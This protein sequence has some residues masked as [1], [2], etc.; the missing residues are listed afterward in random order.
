M[1][2]CL[3][4][5]IFRN[6]HLVN[7]ANIFKI[8]NFC[9][10]HVDI[11]K[12]GEASGD[13]SGSK[14]GFMNKI[15][16]TT[17]SVFLFI[18]FLAACSERKNSA[19][20]S[21]DSIRALA[22]ADSIANAKALPDSNCTPVLCEIMNEEN[23]QRSRLD[24]LLATDSVRTNCYCEISGTRRKLGSRI[25]IVKEF[26]KEKYRS[27]QYH[28][29]PLQIACNNGDLKTMKMLLE[30]GADPNLCQNTFTKPMNIMLRKRDQEG[31]KLLALYKGNIKGC[32]VDVTFLSVKEMKMYAS[33][34]A[35]YNIK[36]DFFQVPTIMEAND[37]AKRKYLLEWGVNPND[38]AKGGE[39][40]LHKL[41]LWGDPA[42]IDL[43]LKYKADLYARDAKGNT[44]L[45]V[46]ASTFDSEM[47]RKLL[48]LYDLDKAHITVDELMTI[49]TNEK[50]E[51]NIAYLKKIKK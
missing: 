6:N 30:K 10:L 7:K 47:L 18:F 12:K 38:T 19:Q 40:L 24:S 39:T 23:I 14:N 33:Y 48:P 26:I 44:P 17:T 46:A 2:W 1:T 50:S 8:T 28:L 49:A 3:V 36:D 34:G 9:S 5:D 51:E 4:L 32:H 35:D 31:V 25:P 42:D 21:E 37:Y 29:T 43:A 20:D 15:Y 16:H 11:N 22:M 13:R 27:Y 41:V 45:H